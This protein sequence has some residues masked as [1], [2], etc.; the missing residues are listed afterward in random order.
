MR[1]SLRRNLVRALT[2]GALAV[3]LSAGGVQAASA[4]GGLAVGSKIW[5]GVG[6]TM[7]V[8]VA[9]GQKTG[10]VRV[11]TCLNQ[12]TMRWHIRSVTTINGMKAVQ[13]Q[14]DAGTCLG[15]ARA[16]RA[17]KAPINAGVCA[18]PAK[19]RSQLWYLMPGLAGSAESLVNVN[20]GL[21]MVADSWRVASNVA[22]RSYVGDLAD[23]SDI[24]TGPGYGDAPKPPLL[25]GRK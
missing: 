8:G 20:S 22:Q 9:G 23:P 19:N 14:N 11:N 1:A 5:L 21:P 6:P 17:E 13:I 12:P 24:F 2:G 4:A 7:C 18:D 3:V 10:P 25:P 16:S 15:P